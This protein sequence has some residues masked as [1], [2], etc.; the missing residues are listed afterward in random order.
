M[1]RLG[2]VAEAVLRLAILARALQLQAPAQTC[3]PRILSRLADNACVH[4]RYLY[5][6]G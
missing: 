4:E 2:P 1:M 6:I 3:R 5:D